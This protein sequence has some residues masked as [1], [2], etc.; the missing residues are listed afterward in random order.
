MGQVKEGELKQQTQNAHPRVFHLFLMDI[1][2]TV[3]LDH[4]TKHAC[5]ES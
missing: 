3:L 5:M 1:A 2:C 4:T